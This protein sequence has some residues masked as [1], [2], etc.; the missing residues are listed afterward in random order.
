M[1]DIRNQRLCRR[2]GWLFTN[3]LKCRHCVGEGLA[4]D[5]IPMGLDLLLSPEQA[6]EIEAKSHVRLE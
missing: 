4:G 3:P 5:G 2:H 6:T 1:V